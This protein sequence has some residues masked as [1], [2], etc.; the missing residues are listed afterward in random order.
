MLNVNRRW[1]DCTKEAIAD[2]QHCVQKVWSAMEGEVCH[3]RGRRAA[4][5]L[6]LL[7][8]LV[9]LSGLEL[10]ALLLQCLDLTA[11]RMHLRRLALRRRLEVLALH[12]QRVDLRAQRLHRRPLPPVPPCTLSAQSCRTTTSRRK[13]LQ[14]INS[15]VTHQ[16]TLLNYWGTEGG[17]RVCRHTEKARRKGRIYGVPERLSTP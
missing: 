16:H 9:L 6:A 2:T 4:V 10:L 8:S 14:Q 15:L 17:T 13:K 3:T 5:L 12:L 7:R 1:V 11:Q